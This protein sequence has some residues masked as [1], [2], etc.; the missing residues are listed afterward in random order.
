MQTSNL[1]PESCAVASERLKARQDAAFTPHVYNMGGY[2]SLFEKSKILNSEPVKDIQITKVDWLRVTTTDLEV[3]NGTM[4]ELLS[5][6]GLLAHAGLDVKWK[7]KGFHGYENSAAIMVWKD[8]DYLTVG[9]IGTSEQGRN[10]GGLLELTGTGCKILQLEYPALWLELFDLLQYHEWRISRVDVALD[11]SGEYA[12]ANGYTVPVLFKQ[13]VNAGLLQSDNLRN[14]N[15]RQSFSTA[16]DWSDLVVGNLTPETYDPIEHCPAGLTAY[17]GNRKSSDDFWRIYE[18]GK[19]LLGQMAEPESIDRGW[20]RIE[21][22]MSRKASGREIPLDVMLRPDEYFCAGRSGARAIMDKLRADMHQLKAA[23]Q[24]QREQFIR[25]KGLLLSKKIHWA[26][27]SYGRLFR[28]LVEQGIDAAEI[29]DWL[30]REDGLKE[31]VFDITDTGH[32]EPY[33]SGLEVMV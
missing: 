12:K 24:W 21:H 3:F 17:I 6:D 30:S 15:M 29:I 4:G 28:T 31:F 7:N 11:L 2:D 5:D 1:T 23:H 14:P 9:N 18:K 10:R 33:Q 13:A 20:I 27:H 19:E 22:E 26:K 25:E 8:N 32:A 16:G